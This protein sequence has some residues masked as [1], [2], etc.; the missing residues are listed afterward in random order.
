MIKRFQDITQQLRAQAGS[1]GGMLAKLYRSNYPVPDG[2]VVMP[3]AFVSNTLTDEA[4]SLLST[5]L[6]ATRGR[7]QGAMYAVR[8]SALYEGAQPSATIL[9]LKTEGEITEAIY[10]VYQPIQTDSSV[11]EGNEQ[12]SQ[13]AVIVQLMIVPDITGV[14]FTAD[15]VT[16]S[17]AYMMGNF[18]QGQ[19]ENR[20]IGGASLKYDRHKGKYEGPEAFR[21]HATKLYRLALELERDL[22][23]P[24]HIE[25]AVARG[26]IYLL[27]VQPIDTLTLGNLDTYD[28]NY[29]L[30]EDALWAN[31][32]LDDAIP[33]VLTPFSWSIGQVLDNELFVIPGYYVWSGNIYGR[34]YTNVSRRASVIAALMG[35]DAKRAL[36]QSGALLAQLP[37]SIDVP[38]HPF[39]R[40][41]LLREML[42]RIK[43]VIK[44][45]L[46]ATKHMPMFLEHTPQWCNNITND[47]ASVQTT[48]ELLNLWRIKI[49]PNTFRAWWT[50]KSGGNKLASIAALDKKLTKLVGAADSQMLLSSVRGE[51]NLA[52][53]GASV[54]IA[55]VIA[56]E[57]NRECYEEKYGHRCV[58]EYEL[59][60]S[61]P[62]ED[63]NWLDKQLEGA[64][65][66][67]LETLELLHKQQAQRK[68]SLIR[69]GAH[70]PNKVKWLE[71]EVSRAAEGADLREACRSEFVRVFRLI[72]AFAL[73]AGELTDIGD[74]V[75]FLYIDEVEKLLMGDD[76]SL[77][78]ISARKVNYEKFKTLP[79]FPAIIRGR[80]DPIE[81]STD[82]NRRMDYYD[83]RK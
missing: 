9:N 73:R 66:S 34:T 31:T 58:Y 24:Q 54:G 27:Q 3:T 75:F 70:Y 55:K 50:A 33:D 41:G 6:S 16:G 43:H 65:E 78:H 17:F 22:R 71:K 57:L 5:Y 80:F 13:V 69:F 67:H 11:E 18:A 48:E 47:I 38:I 45:T 8:S 61:H 4:R 53:M 29:S 2:F 68:D 79:P 81:W 20:L 10:T 46:R 19:G 49:R 23:G 39:S 28:I 26:K 42:P 77:K 30:T 35:S 82:P 72:R 83:G 56:G 15:P 62:A 63:P 40:L 12:A 52:S 51:S 21:K 64:K 37:S 36:S 44:S 59:S 60:V 1:K 7:N 74:D 32:N 25:W 14:L 76:S